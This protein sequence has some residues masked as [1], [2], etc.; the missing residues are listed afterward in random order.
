ML[1]GVLPDTLRAVLL[2]QHVCP[3]Q[4]LPLVDGAEAIPSPND[5]KPGRCRKSDGDHR[6]GASTEDA[7]HQG[8]ESHKAEVRVVKRIDQD[9]ASTVILPRLS[10]DQ[11]VSIEDAAYE[12]QCPAQEA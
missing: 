11:Q 8:D 9:A 1:S 5:I 2:Q 3:W 10:I 7:N 12:E 6:R 4:C